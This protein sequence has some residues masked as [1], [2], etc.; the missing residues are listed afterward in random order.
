MEEYGK[1]L[2]VFFV[3]QNGTLTFKLRKSAFLIVQ[4]L[5]TILYFLALKLTTIGMALALFASKRIIFKNSNKAEAHFK[6][7]KDDFES[8]PTNQR[9][10]TLK[11]AMLNYLDPSQMKKLFGSGNVGFKEG[12]NHT[13]F[14]HA[15]MKARHSKTHM[16]RIINE[17]GQWI[18]DQEKI[19]AEAVHFFTC[20][21]EL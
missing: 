20:L 11:E 5:I 7:A 21:L 17:Q 14:F 3:T 18:D 6:K 4:P 15:F 13:K 9:E 19:G 8:S 12:D 1:R 10:I 2:T 16:S